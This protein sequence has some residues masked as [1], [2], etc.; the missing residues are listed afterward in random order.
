MRKKES[1]DA[2][3]ISLTSDIVSQIPMEKMFKNEIQTWCS[4]FVM[5]WR[6][7]SPGSS[8]YRDRFG[9]MRE[10]EKILEEEEEWKQNEEEEEE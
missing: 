4:N 2:K 1:Y 8:F 3:G 5:I 6:F 10:K 7:T 9:C